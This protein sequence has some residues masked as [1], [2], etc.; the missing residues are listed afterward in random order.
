MRIAILS[1]FYPFRGGISQFNTYLLK[2]LSKKHTIK[3]FNFKRQYPGILFPGKTQKVAADD[4]ALPVESEALLDTINPF[5][6]IRTAKAIAAFRPDVLLTRYWM[7]FFAPSLGSVCGKTAK[8]LEKRGYGETG[9]FRTVAIADNIIPHER[10]FFDIPLAK[11]FVKR[12]S[13]IVTLSHAVEE[14]LKDICPDVKSTTIPHPLYSNFGEKTDTLQARRQLGI[15][16]TD[17]EVLRRKVLLFF[18]LIRDY[19]GLD[20]LLEALPLLDSSYTLVV[21]GEPYG[22]FEKYRQIIE[23]ERFAPVKDNLILIDRYIPDGEVKTYFSAANVSVLPYRS[24]TQSGISSISW[25][26]DV[27]LITT[28]VGGLVES[29][30][31]AGT[32][33]LAENI[34]PQAIASAVEKYFAEN[35]KEEYLYN[36]SRLKE[37]LGW[38]AFASKLEDFINTL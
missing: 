17:E 33:M 24:A 38:E 19:K 2:E 8:M 30:G 31:K 5:T 29:V 15:K 10:H 4:S 34:T 36:I 22:S 20:I 37:E 11:Y 16:G 28:P 14:Q 23:S 13:G 25:N 32:G 12:Q 3:A 27:P 18:G 9:K 1:C 7:S 35:R 21:A 26:F 6:Y